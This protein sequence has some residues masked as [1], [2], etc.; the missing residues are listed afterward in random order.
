MLKIVKITAFE[1]KIPS[2]PKFGDRKPWQTNN[3]I[4]KSRVSDDPIGQIISQ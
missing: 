4:A 2:I 3:L 1:N